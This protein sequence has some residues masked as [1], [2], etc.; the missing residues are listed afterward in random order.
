M[1]TKARI[2]TIAELRDKRAAREEHG[3]F[4]AEGPK[5]VEEL[6]QADNVQADEI[7]AL[8]EWLEDYYDLVESQSRFF[9]EITDAELQR[10]SGLKTPNAVVGV[11][12]FPEFTRGG[13]EASGI[14][15]LLDTIQD[16]GNLGTII[17]TADWFGVRRVICSRNCA[18]AFG[19][20][21]VQATMGSLARVEV[22]YEDLAAALN[23]RPDMSVLAAAIDGES[24]YELPAMDRAYV[25]IG[26]ESRG[27][28]PALL[29][30]ATRTVSV[31]RRGRAES[32]NAAV[33]TGIILGELTARAGK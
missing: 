2:K 19:S 31:P 18:D 3:L 9:M 29:E 11:F 1:L 33:A 32:L 25:L 6:L 7:Y 5:V 14:T 16:P 20:K 4:V 12:R 13:T 23:A 28:S 10:L 15:L 22:I 27:L 30:R 8:G 26:N 21:V 24:I 17:R